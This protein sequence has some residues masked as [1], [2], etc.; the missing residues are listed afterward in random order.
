MARAFYEANYRADLHIHDFYEMNII[1]GGEGWHFINQRRFSVSRGDIF[2][3]PP[4][5]VHGYSPVSPLN[6]YHILLHKNFFPT[7]A[8]EL[9]QLPAFPLLFTLEPMRKP[10]FRYH[11]QADETTLSTIRPLLDALS[12]CYEDVT[13]EGATLQNSLGV[14]IVGCICRLCRE[15]YL[16][17]N[18]RSA[19][20]AAVLAAIHHIQIH[21]AEKLD[22]DALCA[23]IGVSRATLFRYFEQITGLGPAAYLEQYRLRIAQELLCET[24]LSI[25]EISVA[26]G[27]YDSAHFIRRFSHAEKI[28]PGRYRA[29]LSELTHY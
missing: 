6:L 9:K 24:T 2:I 13:P 29:R 27:F 11:L 15:V 21:Y 12:G 20:S 16:S 5:Y 26:C 17:E 19:L 28:T 4:G 22:I 7:Y 23:R 18:W 25:A 8:Q 14:F 1:M 10:G 3:L